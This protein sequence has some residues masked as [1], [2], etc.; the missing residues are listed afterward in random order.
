MLKNF[1]FAF[2][3]SLFSLGA[4]AEIKQPPAPALEQHPQS[5]PVELFFFWSHFCPHC[6]KAKPF[7][8]NLA[9]QYA[10]LKLHSY[11]LVDHP[12]NGTRYAT[13]ARE[14]NTVANAVPGFIFCG[15][16]LMGF[17]SAINSGKDLENKLLACHEKGY[18]P[19]NTPPVKT[20][21]KETVDLPLLGKIDAQAYSLPVFTLIIAALDA[22]NPCAFFVLCFLL[23]LIVHSHN[24]LR[25]AIIGGTFVL[26]SGVM[27][28]VF[29]AA[30]LNVFLYTQ[31]LVFIT[32]LA[33]IIAIV[34][35]VINIK[36]YFFFK[37]GVSLSIP[38][39]AK[40][41]LFQ[42]MRT[43]T[44]TAH[45]PMMLAA[46]AILAIAA[47][48]YELL[49]TAGFP[50]VYTRVLTLNAL[51]SQQYYLYLALYNLIYIVPLLLIVAIFTVTLGNKKLS[52]REG[53][54]L[55]LLSGNMMLGLGLILFFAPDLLNN[56]L[57]SVLVMAIAVA[58]TFVL[59]Q[60]KT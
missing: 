54:V 59:A 46:T 49:C 48:S 17:D 8:E 20:V 32:T 1:L 22:F 30:W 15:Q 16:V 60:R 45:Y 37:Q 36:D 40:P 24:R 58:M 14:L 26:F 12:E 13:M 56:M 2:V 41:K 10:W 31:Q 43:I 29:M 3:F 9:Q 47:N 52:E 33:G 6:L 50:M 53:R 55:K 21:A 57:A 25:I 23:S 4:V 38:E 34:V 11:D 39:T 18:K 28:F 35:G 44:Q 19:A 5:Q 27:Y 42:R 51:S 7:V